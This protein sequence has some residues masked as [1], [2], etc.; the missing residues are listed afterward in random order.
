MPTPTWADWL[1]LSDRAARLR[2]PRM[3]GLYRVRV[4]GEAGLAYVGQSSDLRQRLG[5]LCALYRQE[6]P[7]NDPHTAAPCLWVMRTVEGAEFEFSVAEVAGDV[8]SLKTAECVVVSEHRAEFGRSPLANFGRMP[9]G[10]VKSSGNTKRLA[11]AGRRVRGHQDARAARAADHASVLDVVRDPTA[12]D[13][14]G[15]AWSPWSSTP[16][17]DPAVGVYRV[18][19]AGAEALVYIGQGVVRAR[20]A[21]HVAKSRLVDHRQRAAFSGPIEWSWAPLP[22]HAPAQLLEVEC[23]LIAG[24]ALRLGSAPAAQ[25]LG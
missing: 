2:A 15:Q 9:D 1:S 20:V 19:R 16:V 6:I 4:V 12:P 22:G 21:A 11:E 8:V 25:F 7:Y 23:D 10:W 18:R 24:H 14:A 17:A 3:P 13:W 5:Q